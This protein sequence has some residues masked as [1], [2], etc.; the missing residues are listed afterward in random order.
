MFPVKKSRTNDRGY[1]RVTGESKRTTLVL[2][3][4][5]LSRKEKSSSPNFI[6]DPIL[7]GKTEITFPTNKLHGPMEAGWDSGVALVTRV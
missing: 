2:V 5:L 6:L 3:A 7:I 1:K 4:I